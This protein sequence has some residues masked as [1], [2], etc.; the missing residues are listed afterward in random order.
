MGF[1]LKY[2]DIFSKHQVHLLGIHYKTGPNSTK[3]SKESYIVLLGLSWPFHHRLSINNG[4]RLTISGLVE[5][6]FFKKITLKMK[7]I[8]RS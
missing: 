2:F 6:N 8:Q 1:S 4:Q 3:K 5:I 7:Y